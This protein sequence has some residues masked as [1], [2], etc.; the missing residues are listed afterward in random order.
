[1][2]VLQLTFTNVPADILLTIEPEDIEY[3]HDIGILTPTRPF[4]RGSHPWSS[5]ID[6]YT[7]VEVP[8][9]RVPTWASRT[10]SRSAQDHHDQQYKKLMDDI[11]FL[12]LQSSQENDSHEEILDD[13]GALREADLDGSIFDPS[14]PFGHKACRREIL[15]ST[16]T[17]VVRVIADKG[18]FLLG[19]IAGQPLSVYIPKVISPDM[20]IETQT[21]Y[22]MDLR[23]TSGE[24]N[25][26]RVTNIHPKLYTKCMLESVLVVES[27]GD[28]PYAIPMTDR[29][30]RKFNLPMAPE[31]IGAM[32]GKGGYNIDCLKTNARFWGAGDRGSWGDPDITILPDGEGCKVIFHEGHAVTGGIHGRIWWHPL[33]VKYVVHRLHC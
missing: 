25:P 31:H 24:R 4:A 2:A 32:I 21:F 11:D 22:L 17:E 13:L 20:E 33:D 12:I 26:W 15:P 27:L 10:T 3:G 6:D 9:P 19:S 7:P 23:F 1:M 30:T 14:E 5:V 8:E 29:T 18:H 28:G 16:A